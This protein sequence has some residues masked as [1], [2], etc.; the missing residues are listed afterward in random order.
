MARILSTLYIAF[1]VHLLW[2]KA[3]GK[4]VNSEYT[5]IY[6][7][8]CVCVIS[9]TRYQSFSHPLRLTPQPQPINFHCQQPPPTFFCRQPRTQPLSAADNDNEHR[10]SG[11]RH[12][13]APA[14]TSWLAWHCSVIA[15]PRCHHGSSCLPL[16][17]H[18]HNFLPPAITP[19]FT[20]QEFQP[21][22]W[23]CLYFLFGGL[24]MFFFV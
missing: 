19:I 7:Y 9:K 22:V 5:N 6:I 15:W 18:L 10:F 21:W 2:Y 20:P 23:I 24:S 8:L 17:T 11:W 3:R 4:R 14:T 16:A 12:Q 1:I 13:L